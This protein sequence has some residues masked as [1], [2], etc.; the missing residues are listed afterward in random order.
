ME[1]TRFLHGAHNSPLWVSKIPFKGLIIPFQES[2]F[3]FRYIH[4]LNSYQESYLSFDA[5]NGEWQN[6]ASTSSILQP[7]P[8]M[9]V[10]P[11]TAMYNMWYNARILLTHK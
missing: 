3:S 8:V 7:Y 4:S 6:T 1:R 2:D 5:L 9:A 10:L 11:L